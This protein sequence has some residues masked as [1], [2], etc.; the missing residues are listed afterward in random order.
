MP[1]EGW[2]SPNENPNQQPFQYFVYAACVTE[3]P[4]ARLDVMFS[5]WIALAMWAWLARRPQETISP[6]RAALFWLGMAGAF[7]TK[8]Q[9]WND[10]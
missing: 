10:I 8:G 1:M 6:F 4:A 7:F 9:I 3:V 2:Y 5:G